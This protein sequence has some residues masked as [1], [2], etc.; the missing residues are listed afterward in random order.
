MKKDLG[1]SSASA[2]AIA[3][4]T[5][6][7]VSITVIHALHAGALAPPFVL[8]DRNGNRV[9]LDGLLRS[10]PVVLNFLRGS[11]CL[12]GEESLARFLAM[13]GRIGSAGARAVAVAPPDTSMRQHGVLPMPE[14]VDTDLRVATSFGLTFDLPESLRGR[15]LDLGYTPPKVR[16]SGDFLVPVP[17]TYLI[18]NDGIVVFAHVDF[19]YRKG[20]EEESLLKAVRALHGL[21]SAR[22]RRR[23]RE[24]VDHHLA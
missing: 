22:L 16:K 20:F 18:D 11:W 3:E 6:A 2:D 8:P 4:L 5:M 19:D 21:R 17:A 9:A 23:V 13:H 14:L 15:Y 10:G 24:Q 7:S 1:V 12:F